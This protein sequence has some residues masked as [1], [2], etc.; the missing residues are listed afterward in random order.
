MRHIPSHD[1]SQS[2]PLALCVTAEAWLCARPHTPF[3]TP[4]C[5]P[6]Q[7]ATPDGVAGRGRRRSEPVRHDFAG[8]AC[9]RGRLGD[10]ALTQVPSCAPRFAPSRLHRPPRGRP[11][12]RLHG[13]GLPRPRAARSGCHCRRCAVAQ[14]Q[15]TRLS[16]GP[17]TLLTST[18]PRRRGCTFHG[19]RAGHRG[20]RDAV[21]RRHSTAC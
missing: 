11:H 12:Q 20:G 15:H 5:A 3:L 13:L 1:M 17:N 9:E 18:L 10:L 6:A 14:L 21:R 16:L 2:V 7:R 8:A 19:A 4:H